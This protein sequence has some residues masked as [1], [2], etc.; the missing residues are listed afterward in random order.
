MSEPKRYALI[1]AA[2]MVYNIAMWDGETPWTHGAAQLI[3]SDTAGIDWMYADGKFKPSP[4][5]LARKPPPPPGP[6]A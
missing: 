5:L 6:K 2:G 3:Q 4:E 1:N